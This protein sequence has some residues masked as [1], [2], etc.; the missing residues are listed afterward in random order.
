[1]SVAVATRLESSSAVE[2]RPVKALVAGSSPASPAKK[3]KQ[4]R[5][6]TN[7]E[8]E[9]GFKSIEWDA[10]H[11]HFFWYAEEAGMIACFP[12]DLAFA[13]EKF[14]ECGRALDPSKLPNWP[15]KPAWWKRLLS[16][17]GL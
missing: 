14:I 15:H 2:R 6:L 9:Q 4:L 13:A 12:C 3:E 7:R 5:I 11:R 17:I 10:K 8:F 1:M 16:A